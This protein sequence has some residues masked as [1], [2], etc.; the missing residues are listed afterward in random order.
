MNSFVNLNGDP[1]T[2]FEDFERLA[3]SCFTLSALA[4]LWFA[5]GPG[6]LT[7]SQHPEPD[8]IVVETMDDIIQEIDFLT[9][10]FNDWLIYDIF[11]ET[12]DENVTTFDDHIKCWSVIGYRR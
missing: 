11:I 7:F 3:P 8:L 9:M 2:M 4:C 5:F 12:I 6:S 1:V 10:H